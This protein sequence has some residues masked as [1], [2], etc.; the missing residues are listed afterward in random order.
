[1]ST[2]QIENR[3]IDDIISEINTRMKT[4]GIEAEESDFT[5]LA[6]YDRQPQVLDSYRWL[7]CYPVRGSNEGYYV[8]IA[9]ISHSGGT[10]THRLL[11]CAK[12]YSTENAWA[13]AR[14]VARYLDL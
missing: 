2:I 3:P 4:D 12:M 5:N 1:M 11:A 8:H 14:A 9:T 6:R 7:V 10:S 13:I